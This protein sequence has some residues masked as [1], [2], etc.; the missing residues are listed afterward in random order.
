MLPFHMFVFFPKG[1]KEIY[2]YIY[3][4]IVQHFF[5]KYI[6]HIAQIIMNIKY[7]KMDFYII[8]WIQINFYKLKG[9]KFWRLINALFFYR[10]NFMPLLIHKPPQKSTVFYFKNNNQINLLNPYIYIEKQVEEWAARLVVTLVAIWFGS[11]GTIVEISVNSPSHQNL[12]SVI[13]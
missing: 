1:I 8:N 12:Y 6:L 9:T 3:T 10:A 13:I 11:K 4:H 5:I 7:I 2:I